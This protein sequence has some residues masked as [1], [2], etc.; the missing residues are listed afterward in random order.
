MR[1]EIF[2]LQHITFQILCLER[3]PRGDVV[4]SKSTSALRYKI[5]AGG[6]LLKYT[7][8]VYYI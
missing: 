4:K 8:E 7:S 1:A 6:I 3:N 5:S 2:S